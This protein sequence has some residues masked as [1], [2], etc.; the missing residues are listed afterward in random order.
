MTL[1][2]RG[3]DAVNR[4]EMA[5]GLGNIAGAE[6]FLIYAP[7]PVLDSLHV[8]LWLEGL[9]QFMCKRCWP[10]PGVSVESIA[11]GIH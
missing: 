11:F 4:G 3:A 6:A 10:P 2:Q 5:T 9:R 1:N 8:Y 7:L